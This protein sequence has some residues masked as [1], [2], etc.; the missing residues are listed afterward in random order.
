MAKSYEVLHD[1]WL[2]GRAYASGSHAILG[3]EDAAG[4]IRAGLVK[5]DAPV[6]AQ[7]A[8]QGAAPDEPAER[9]QDALVSKKKKT[10]K[11]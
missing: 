4:Y 2:R 5:G 9:H 7:P 11:E 10:P 1:T 6:A 8:H 3:D